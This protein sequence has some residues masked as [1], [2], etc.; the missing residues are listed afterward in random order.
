MPAMRRALKLIFIGLAIYVILFGIFYALSRQV[1]KVFPNEASVV[2]WIV[3]IGV[4]A[5]FTAQAMR[6]ICDTFKET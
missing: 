2:I 1:L 5:V 3:V 6:K 4:P